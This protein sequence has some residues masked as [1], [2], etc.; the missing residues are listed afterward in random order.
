M[1]LFGLFGGKRESGESGPSEEDKKFKA[2][3]TGGEANESIYTKDVKPYI[4]MKLDFEDQ[5]PETG[6]KAWYYD[7][8]ADM[9]ILHGVIHIRLREVW[10]RAAIIRPVF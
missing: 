5:N 6:A 1:G 10:W 4:D 2:P 7:G 3:E 8:L 9:V